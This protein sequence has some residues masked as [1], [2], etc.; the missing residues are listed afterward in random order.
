MDSLTS[1]NGWYAAFLRA[2]TLSI[3]NWSLISI[4]ELTSPV[5]SWFKYWCNDLSIS[6]INYAV[7][8]ALIGE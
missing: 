4:I 3:N 7:N 2:S 6:Q 5:R 8:D 1:E